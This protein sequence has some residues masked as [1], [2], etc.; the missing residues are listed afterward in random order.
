[1]FPCA[2]PWRD[3]NTEN[4]IIRRSKLT[5]HKPPFLISDNMQV[6][7]EAGQVSFYVTISKQEKVAA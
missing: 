5:G 2:I 7:D 4:F 6:P 1:M 3:I